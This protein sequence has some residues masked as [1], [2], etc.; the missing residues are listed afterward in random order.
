MF[1]EWERKESMQEQSA[2]DEK[3]IMFLMCVCIGI[4]NQRCLL[5]FTFHSLSLCSSNKNSAY[6]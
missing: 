4:V 1:D 5:L 6:A 2:V 3:E